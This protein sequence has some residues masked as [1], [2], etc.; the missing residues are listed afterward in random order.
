MRRRILAQALTALAVAAAILAAGQR[1][2]PMPLRAKLLDVR[3]HYT[4]PLDGPFHTVAEVVMTAEIEDDVPA[5]VRSDNVY[6]LLRVGSDER[7]VLLLPNGTWTAGGPPDRCEVGL[8]LDGKQVS[9]VD[10]IVLSGI[11]SSRRPL[12]VQLRTCNRRDTAESNWMDFAPLRT[13]LHDL[14]R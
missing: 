4:T 13:K 9:G 11:L 7:D 14:L 12:A 3:V 1:P 8:V 10:E 2:R 6:G 5:S